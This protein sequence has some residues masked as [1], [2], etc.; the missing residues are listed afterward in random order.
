[1]AR[2]SLYETQDHLITALDEG[3]MR[4]EEVNALMVQ[5]EDAIITLNGY[6]RYLLRHADNPSGQV[7]EPSENYGELSGPV[8]DPPNADQPFM[9]DL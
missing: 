1:M 5:I 2:G 8:G 6:M 4:E 3:W 9:A 7:S